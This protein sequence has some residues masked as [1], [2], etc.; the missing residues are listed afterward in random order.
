VVI[1]STS[2]KR[3]LELT[4]PLQG[5]DLSHFELS[6]ARFDALDTEGTDLSGAQL[7]SASFADANA[8]NSRFVGANMEGANLMGA[9]LD[10]T[11]LTEADLYWCLAQGAEF[12]GARLVNA[13]LGG[14]T[15]RV[16]TSRVQ[17]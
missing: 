13:V 3:L 11:D 6:S 14:Q 16:L 5:S 10:S 8:A 12:C 4:G 17:I 15:L 2:G 9:C 1:V 7:A